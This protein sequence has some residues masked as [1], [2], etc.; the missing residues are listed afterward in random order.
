MYYTLE[1]QGQECASGLGRDSKLMP[2]MMVTLL[3]KSGC[4]QRDE[5]TLSWD[6]NDGIGDIQE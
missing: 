5:T 1:R 3:F 2:L 4:A 6:L